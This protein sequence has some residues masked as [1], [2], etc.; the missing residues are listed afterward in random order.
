M[1]SKDRFRPDG[2]RPIEDMRKP[3]AVCAVEDQGPW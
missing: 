2:M 3:G 1:E